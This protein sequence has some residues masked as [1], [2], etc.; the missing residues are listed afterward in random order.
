MS[1]QNAY[2][3]SASRDIEFTPAEEQTEILI[4]QEELKKWLT[5]P[6]TRDFLLFLGKR[7]LEL[8]N[9]SRNCVKVNLN[10]ENITRNLLKAIA[11]R[12]VIDFLVEN[13]PPVKE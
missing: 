12:E 10:H 6:F 13:K 2:N 7:E 11:Y 1:F 4:K 3:K 5:H 8:L 9:N